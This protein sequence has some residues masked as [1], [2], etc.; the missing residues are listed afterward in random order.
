MHR[1]PRD[2]IQIKSTWCSSIACKANDMITWEFD[3][4]YKHS[5][6]A[7]SLYMFQAQKRP[8]KTQNIDVL[9]H[10]FWQ[11]TKKDY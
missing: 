9:F 4:I 7:F 11:K 8:M 3:N 1:V 10:L 6:N 5:Y 2:K